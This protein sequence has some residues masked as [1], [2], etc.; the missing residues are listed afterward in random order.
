MAG[1]N[2]GTKYG[3]KFT[4]TKFGGKSRPTGTKFLK[5]FVPSGCLDRNWPES[6]SNPGDF[7]AAASQKQGRDK[8]RDIINFVPLGVLSRLTPIGCVGA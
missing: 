7:T 4:G 2:T 8:S 3:T 1:Q 6:R 5:N